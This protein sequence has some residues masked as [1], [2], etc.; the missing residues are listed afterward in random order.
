[1]ELD[2]RERI[3]SHKSSSSE[4]KVEPSSISKVSSMAINCL[5]AE[6]PSLARSF[7]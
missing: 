2:K 1:M 6:N 3:E 7:S 4:K 5:V